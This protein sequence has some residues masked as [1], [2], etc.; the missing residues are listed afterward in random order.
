MTQNQAARHAPA[1]VSLTGQWVGL[2]LAP[3]FGAVLLV[4]F[5]AFPGFF[6]PMSPRLPAGD[7][8]TFYR[9][10]Q[11]MIRFS[12]IVFNLCG[13]MLVPFFM[14]IVVQ[15]KRMATPSHVLAYAYLSAV[16]GGVTLF[17]IADLMWLIGA[18][19]PERDPQLIL[20]LNDL[21]WIIFTAPVGMTVAANFCLAL[22]VYLDARPQ[23]VFPRWVAPFSILTG[24]AMTPAVCGAIV[25]T[26]PLAW[27]GVITFWLRIG[28]YG[29]FIAVMFFV[30]RAAIQRQALEAT[31]DT[32]AA[33]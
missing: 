14:V 16:V 9:E 26:G 13:V 7:V 17:A 32:K 5:V 11:A 6:P 29:L 22:A 30:L 27:D 31:P 20:L 18:F 23:P 12:M 3:V 21:A 15:M 10:N 33:S 19:R 24:L 4:A 25:Q 8:A 2:W 28:A 1:P